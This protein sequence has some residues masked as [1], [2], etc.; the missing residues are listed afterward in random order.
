MHL[1]DN[2][3]RLLCLSDLPLL[4]RWRNNPVVRRWMYTDHVITLK[5]HLQWYE[6]AS[7]DDTR[8]LLIFESAG[9]AQGFVNLHRMADRRIGEWGFYAAPCAPRGTGRLLGA[10]AL[11]YAFEELDLHKLCGEVIA[12]NVR[13]IR[14]HQ[15]LGFL[16]EGI[17]RE[18]YFDGKEYQDV[19]CF[20]LLAD[21][22]RSIHL[23][24]K[25]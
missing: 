16:C 2:R 1:S 12:T 9:A 8:T 3:L 10:A 11:R 19:H 7:K 13:S 21:E 4:L 17:L 15:A 18:H 22:W 25:A 14:L 23:G 20:G 24:A 6:S 5:E